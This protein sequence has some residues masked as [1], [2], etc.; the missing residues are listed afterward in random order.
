MFKK[1]IIL[2]CGL[3]AMGQ[4][5]LAQG[6]YKHNFDLTAG[7]GLQT[8]QFSLNEGGEQSPKFGWAFNAN[9]RYQFNR[10][11]GLGVG[12]GVSFYKTEVQY[13]N[14]LLSNDVMDEEVGE[15]ENYR[16]SFKDW[17][18]EQKLLN[19]E[20]PVALYFQ[21]PLSEKWTFI[22]DLGVKA[23]I[24]VSKEYKS[25]SGTIE[26]TGYFDCTNVEYSNLPQ[27]NLS[28]Q[29]GLS[30]DAD[31]KSVIVA[32]FVDAG[33]QCDLKN[34]NKFYM[35]VYFSY[36]LTD[37]CNK[38]DNMLYDGTNY[39]GM[40]S[41]D[42]V[43]KAHLMGAGVKVG[44][45]FC[46]PHKLDTTG[47]ESFSV[48]TPVDNEVTSIDSSAILASKHQRQQVDSV[49]MAEARNK[50]QRDQRLQ[51]TEVLSQQQNQKEKVQNSVKWLNTKLKYNFDK[52]PI[53]DESEESDYN[54]GVLAAFI[55]DNPDK[56]IVVTGYTGSLGS[57]DSNFKTGMKYALSMKQMLMDAG[58]PSDNI[59]CRSMGSKKPL[60]PNTSADNRKK[61]NRI[62]I[63]VLY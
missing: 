52:K 10:H 27:H 56:K 15:E 5:L 48:P 7:G 2:L 24:P 50:R 16:V 35:G 17:G 29:D 26:S 59:L 34:D 58:I 49:R 43:D 41:S 63:S 38:S 54:I 25:V 32:G 61:N 44:F 42:V 6:Y 13:D 51:E 53:F 22:S 28:A 45:T 1:E 18:E 40:M 3:L 62:V 9:Y 12:V 30:G 11:W 4:G 55:M 46:R 60:Y 21:A 47:I 37:F 39:V 20:I 57:E 14:L 33:V 31:I 36:S 23:M 8:A 19:V